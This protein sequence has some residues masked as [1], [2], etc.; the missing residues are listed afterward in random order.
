MA[1][2]RKKPSRAKAPRTKKPSRTQSPR[3]STT[4]PARWYQSLGKSDTDPSIA[5]AKR[6]IALNEKVKKLRQFFSGF[7]ASDGYD[8]RHID[9][10]HAARVRA[11]DQYGSFLNTLTASPYIRATAHSKQQRDA[12]GR[13]TGQFYGGT[14][15]PRAFVVH[16]PEAALRK[17]K[18]S[19]SKGGQVQVTRDLPGVR[20]VM[21]TYLFSDYGFNPAQFTSVDD[22]IRATKKMIKAKNGMPPGHYQLESMLHGPIWNAMDRGD[23][24]LNLQHSIRDSGARTP[25]FSKGL[26]GYRRYKDELSAEAKSNAIKEARTKKHSKE[27]RFERANEMREKVTKWREAKG[28]KK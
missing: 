25:N 26:L 17:L 27:A 16:H 19:V 1:S 23:I 11:A 9:R 14:K 21:T 10:W 22:V 7:D 6:S 28:F 18:V 12:L 5:R 15:Q 3:L 24:I 13:Y 8:L 20:T 4:R 2:K